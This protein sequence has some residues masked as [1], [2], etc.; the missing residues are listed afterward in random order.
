[1]MLRKIKRLIQVVW[2]YSSPLTWLA[3]FGLLI[4]DEMNLIQFKRWDSFGVAEFTPL[5]IL[6]LF[7]SPR[8][9][10]RLWAESRGQSGP[11]FFAVHPRTALPATIHHERRYV[12]WQ[13]WLG[14]LFIFFWF[15]SAVYAIVKYGD[16][17]FNWFEMDAQRWAKKQVS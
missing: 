13:L 14:P 12:Q 3:W 17:I 11:G 15:P 6:P 7:D 4:L 8:W 2:L 16:W 10:V 9:W 1:M 5:R